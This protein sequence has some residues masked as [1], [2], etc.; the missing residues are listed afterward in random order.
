MA[1]KFL[2]IY[3]IIELLLSGFLV[4]RGT[5]V[6]SAFIPELGGVGVC[7]RPMQKAYY[8]QDL[9]RLFW[10]YYSSTSYRMIVGDNNV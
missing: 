1:H 2:L 4:P 9:K 7:P 3:F 6:K 5:F 10:I 8:L